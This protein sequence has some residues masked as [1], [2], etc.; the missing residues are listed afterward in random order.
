[1]K[2]FDQNHDRDYD[3][4]FL[5]D[6]IYPLINDNSMIHESFHK[7]EG[8]KCLNFPVDFDS[9]FHFVREYVFEDENRLWDNIC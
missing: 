7:Y 8:E 3:Q 4:N 5:R 2:D 9:E 1:M 6:F